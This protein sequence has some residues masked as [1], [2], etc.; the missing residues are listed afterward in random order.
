MFYGLPES[1]LPD[2]LWVLPCVHLLTWILYQVPTVCSTLCNEHKTLGR[3]FQNLVCRW[4]GDRCQG[5]VWRTL[6]LAQLVWPRYSGIICWS[7]FL[8][9]KYEATENPYITW[10]AAQQPS[11]CLFPSSREAGKESCVWN[12]GSF[13]AM[14]EG[15]RKGL[16][17]T[18]G[19]LL[20]PQRV[21]A[22]NKSF[23]FWSSISSLESHLLI[24]L[25]KKKK[26]AYPFRVLHTET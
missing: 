10:K 2:L 20:G 26:S 21:I 16:G 24:T 14:L 9:L 22:T 7:T 17:P 6:V 3:I 11:R 8:F 12:L 23:L 19:D 18:P 1:W 15:Q 5:R 25:K 4:V 13:W